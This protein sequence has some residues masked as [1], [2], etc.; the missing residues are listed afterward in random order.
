MTVEILL[1][2][3][4]ESPEQIFLFFGCTACLPHADP[5]DLVL[6]ICIL[7]MIT[8]IMHHYTLMLILRNLAHHTL[9][10]GPPPFHPFPSPWQLRGPILCCLEAAVG[11]SAA[12]EVADTLAAAIQNDS[13]Y[14]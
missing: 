4:K 7:H 11:L 9:W 5:K 12:A 14:A 13:N 6:S 8:H 10:A 2:Y 1:Q 3:Q